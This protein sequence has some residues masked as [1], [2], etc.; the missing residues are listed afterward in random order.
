MWRQLLLNTGDLAGFLR[1][2]R[3]DYPD[4]FLEDETNQVRGLWLQL[5]EGPWMEELDPLADVEMAVALVR[6]LLDSGLI[7]E[8]DTVAEMALRQHD[9][10][11]LSRLLASPWTSAPFV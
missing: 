1:A 9:S 4:Q 8:A 5:L 3:E 11:E 7:E 2:L 6:D 10:L